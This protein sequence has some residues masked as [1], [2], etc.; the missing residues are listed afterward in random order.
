M[1]KANMT[2]FLGSDAHRKNTSYTEVREAISIVDKIA[3]KE[4][5]AE[6]TE[7]NPRCIID[8]QR[9][10]I[11]EPKEIKVSFGEKLKNLFK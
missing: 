3:G 1:L 7:L 8:N 11:D 2:H 4:K 6:L 10:E 5:R 9:I